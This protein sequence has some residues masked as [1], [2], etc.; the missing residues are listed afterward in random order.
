M[1]TLPV[2]MAIHDVDRSVNVARQVSMIT[3]SDIRCVQACQVYTII[4]Q[5]L[6]AG[7]TGEA[8]VDDALDWASEP[9]HAVDQEVQWALVVNPD[10]PATPK[11]M[12][13]GG[14]V[15]DSLRAAVWAVQQ[16]A[17]AV[18]TLTHLVNLGHDADTTGAIAGG[19]LGTRWGASAWP[20]R[21]ISKLETQVEVA[22]VSRQLIAMRGE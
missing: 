18:D 22:A 17:P 4:V 3:H 2:A 8:A 9:S 14:Y 7:K 5:S 16:S 19:L 10:M 15:I 13:T 20:W 12:W 1:R 6:L 11:S 21:W